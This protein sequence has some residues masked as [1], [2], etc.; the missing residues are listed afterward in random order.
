MIILLF[1]YFHAGEEIPSA[2]M[3][4]VDKAAI[5]PFMTNLLFSNVLLKEAFESWNLT[6]FNEALDVIIKNFTDIKPLVASN[7]YTKKG[8]ELAIEKCQHFKDE[9]AKTPDVS[10]RS[11]DQFVQGSFNALTAITLAYINVTVSP[12]ILGTIVF[13]RKFMST[14]EYKRS[15]LLIFCSHSNSAKRN[16]KRQ[17]QSIS[18]GFE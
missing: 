7:K 15:L 4:G 6:V 5:D 9:L 2:D 3:V 13:A 11:L 1:R 10:L 18:Y 17:S 8:T 16:S 14:I 12:G